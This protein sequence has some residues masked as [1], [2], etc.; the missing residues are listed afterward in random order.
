MFEIVYRCNPDEGPAQPR[1]TVAAEARTRLLQGNERFANSSPSS[2]PQEI[3]PIDLG[4]LGIDEHADVPRQQPFAAVLS[5]SD[6]RVPVEMIF[7]QACNDLFVVR[8]AGNVMT[9]E[10]VGSL[11][12]AVQNLNENVKLIV[13]LGHSCC[14]AVTAAVDAH[15]TNATFGG[16]ASDVGLRAI[17]ERVLTSVRTG[18]QALERAGITKLSEESLYKQRLVEMSI[19]LNA[20]MT[21][22]SL[23]Q[24]MSEVATYECPVVYGVYDLASR[25]VRAP[26]LESDAEAQLQPHLADPPSSV[27]DFVSLADRLAS[28]EG[29]LS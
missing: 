29:T 4:G 5:C 25:L 19:V 11:G 7:R 2:P 3:V 15:L 12:F 28:S 10:G 24:A 26:R 13:V 23:Q 8:L 9:D 17:V 27:G 16:T 14:G 18:A 1:P 20:A 22:M 6:A 21:A